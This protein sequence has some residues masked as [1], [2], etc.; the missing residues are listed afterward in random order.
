M[1]DE[2]GTSRLCEMCCLKR[3]V[4]VRDR[5]YGKDSNGENILGDRRLVGGDLHLPGRHILTSLEVF[6]RRG[7]FTALRI[8][9][10]LNGGDLGLGHAAEF[11]ALGCVDRDRDS[12]PG[13][14]LLE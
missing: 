7:R 1:R 5:A 14:D 2:A 10:T 6:Q 3:R 4:S 9:E 12:L 8:T 11:V 13:L